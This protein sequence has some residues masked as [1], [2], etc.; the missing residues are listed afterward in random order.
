MASTLFQNGLP[1]FVKILNILYS[2]GHT[3]L[4]K[5]HHHVD[6]IRIK[7]VWRDFRLLMPASEMVNVK[8]PIGKSIFAVNLPLKLFRATVANFDLEILILSIPSFK[9]VCRP[10]TCSQKFEQNRMVQTTRNFELFDQKSGFLKP[11]S[12]KP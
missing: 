2:L 4:F 8:Y 11:F 12:T 10:T 3:I 6:Q 7:Y 9:N 1:F 5:F